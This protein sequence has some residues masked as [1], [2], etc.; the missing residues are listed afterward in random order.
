MLKIVRVAEGKNSTLSHLYINSLFCCY[1]LE[2]SIRETKVPGRT[3]IP[4]GTYQLQLNTRA[5]MN[6]R[7][8]LHY[9]GIHKGMLEIAGID[10]FSQVFLHIGNY[11][12]ETA[13]CPLTGHYWAQ[14]NGDYQ[15]QQS[16]FAYQRIY[17]QLLGLLQ[18]GQ[19][20]VRVENKIGELSNTAHGK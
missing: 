18:K 7:Y 3:C 8:K 10:N 13:G 16:A 19:L 1:L 9:P 11:H 14:I 4:E 20:E 6:T 5:G 2:D 15:V 12:S 17:P